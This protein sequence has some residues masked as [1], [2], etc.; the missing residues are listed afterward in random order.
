MGLL[1]R[2][3][4]ERHIGLVG[5][6]GGLFGVRKT[7]VERRRVGSW[8]SYISTRGYQDQAGLK[9]G[10][11]VASNRY[12]FPGQPPKVMATE[13][14]NFSINFIPSEHNCGAVSS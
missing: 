14:A 9:N 10:N 6:T 5:R 3:G 12:I 1:E 4:A 7:L 2:H 11:L 13:N 8:S